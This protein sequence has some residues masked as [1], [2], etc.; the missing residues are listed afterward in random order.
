MRLE[1]REFGEIEYNP[2]EDVVVF[3]EG[4]PAFEEETEFVRIRLP[5]AAPLEVL[6]SRNTRELAFVTVPV[7]LLDPEYEL[8]AE[9]V[10]LQT[11][12]WCSPHRPRIGEDVLCL[13]IVTLAGEPSANLLAPLVIH[14]ATRRGCQ[15]IQVDS[16]YSCRH[17]L[18][19][20]SAPES[21]CS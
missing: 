13:A 16:P 7:K 15:I 8:R 18:R 19:G 1:T 21:V 14:P 2:E 20:P 4:L 17:P 9:P 10:Q 6:Q 5:D 12:G 11:I 3:P